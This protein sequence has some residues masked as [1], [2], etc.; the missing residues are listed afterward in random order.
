MPAAAPAL[1]RPALPTRW[2][3]I[4]LFAV[5]FAALSLVQAVELRVVSFE[6][7][8]TDGPS[9]EPT[10]LNGDRFLVDKGAYGLTLPLDEEAIDHWADPAPG[11]VVVLRSPADGVDIIKRVIGVAGDR[12]EIRDDVVYR[13]G[14]A[15]SRGSPQP[16]TEADVS[17]PEERDEDCELVEERIG[18]R[19]WRT[20]HSRTS[21][22]ESMPERVVPEGT[23]FVLGDHRDRSNDSRN[24]RIGFVD[25]RRVRGPAMFVYWSDHHRTGSS[26]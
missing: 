21:P 17:E 18:D 13:N 4:A 1:D 26:L 25:V 14:E 7:F 24:P 6:A 9:M 23:V 15:L 5:P 3:R 2:G 12:I 19:R 22:S 8:E 20:M 10:L 16:C 11:D